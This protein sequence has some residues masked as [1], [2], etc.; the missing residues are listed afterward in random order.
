MVKVL[1]LD[2]KIA[3]INKSIDKKMV[4]GTYCSVLWLT[5]HNTGSWWYVFLLLWCKS[6]L[7]SIYPI[8]LP[9]KQNI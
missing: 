8:T 9:M 4:L 5:K 7:V 6:M 3:N 2:T 1:F